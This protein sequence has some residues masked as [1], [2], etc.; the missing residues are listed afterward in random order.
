MSHANK[1]YI[2]CEVFGF[3]A[4]NDTCILTILI[5]L[6]KTK[7]CLTSSNIDQ[8]CS[9]KSPNNQLESNND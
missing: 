5:F 8:L 2:Y 3:S 9:Q 7:N 1:Y 4:D 6:F